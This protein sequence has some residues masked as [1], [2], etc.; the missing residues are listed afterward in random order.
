[1]RYQE[2]PWYIRLWRRRWYLMIP[3]WTFQF[4]RHPWVDPKTGRLAHDHPYNSFKVAWSIA[5]GTADVKM[6]WTYT[7]DEVMNKTKS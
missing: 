4:M 2:S 5:H 7:W 1:M 6:N 3:W